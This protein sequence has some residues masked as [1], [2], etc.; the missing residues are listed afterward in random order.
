MPFPEPS[1]YTVRGDPERLLPPWLAASRIG[2]GLYRTG[3]SYI[4]NQLAGSPNGFGI[5]S[6]IG[7]SWG[8]CT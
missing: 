4:L 6:T 5:G 1:Q 8:V 7:T 2:Q 3:K